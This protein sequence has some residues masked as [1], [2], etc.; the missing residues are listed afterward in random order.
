MCG[1]FHLCFGQF[2]TFA[3]QNVTFVDPHFDANDAKCCV[4]FGLTIIDVGT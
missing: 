1:S 4:G 3:W 2:A